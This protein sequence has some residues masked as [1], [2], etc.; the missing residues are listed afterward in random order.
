MK[1]HA[2]MYIPTASLIPQWE[3]LPSILNDND[4]TLCVYK[5]SA[6]LCA[7]MTLSIGSLLNRMLLIC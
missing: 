5:F 4:Y 3:N 2:Y 6:H 7:I 1:V